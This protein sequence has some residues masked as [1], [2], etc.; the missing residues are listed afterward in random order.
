MASAASA[1]QRSSFRDGRVG[2]AAEVAALDEVHH[3]AVPAIGQQADTVDGD[4][5]RVP[6]P[7]QKGGLLAETSSGRLVP[8]ERLAEEKLERPPARRYRA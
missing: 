5:A 2:L 4:D 3:Q 7:G 8:A 1:T 6:Q